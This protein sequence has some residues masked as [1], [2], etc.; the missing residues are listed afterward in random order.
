MLAFS[1]HHLNQPIQNKMI[2]KQTL[3][4]G[5]HF[6]ITSKIGE[7]NFFELALAMFVYKM[8]KDCN[9]DVACE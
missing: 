3:T 6:G 4:F 1:L 7:R 5:I 8:C 9:F 2:S